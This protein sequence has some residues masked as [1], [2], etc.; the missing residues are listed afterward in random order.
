MTATEEATV[1]FSHV[2]LYVDHLEDLADYKALE[3]TLNQFCWTQ[4]H[5][6]AIALAR[7]WRDEHGV[8]LPYQPQK[9][10]IVKQWIAGLGFRIT[11]A[12]YPSDE[13]RANTRSLLVTSKDFNGIQFV[14][15]AVA[16]T[17]ST[18]LTDEYRHFDAGKFC[19][20]NQP[21]MA[22]MSTARS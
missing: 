4:D 7:R 9:R 22:S 12:R 13:V 11:A 14:V 3:T 2:H 6:N 15:T 18:S 16:D 17:E 20:C 21:V 10:D 5:A 1:S 19:N 8:Q